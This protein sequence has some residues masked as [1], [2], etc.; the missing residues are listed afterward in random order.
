MLE[1]KYDRLINYFE[2]R[3]T[4]IKEP[5]ARISKDEVLRMMFDFP[6]MLAMSLSDKIKP[7]VNALD[8]K[9]LGFADSSRVLKH[10]PAILGDSIKR[11]SLQIKL[12]K[13]TDTLQFALRKPRTFRTSPELMYA[14]I[15]IWENNDKVGVPFITTKRMHSQ[16]GIESDKICELHDIKTEYGD[17]EYFDGR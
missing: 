8:Y 5:F 10:N 15:K 9:H 4:R 3:N 16:Y 11:T 17:D 12:L 13:D 6:T 1:R 14:L 7:V 2:K